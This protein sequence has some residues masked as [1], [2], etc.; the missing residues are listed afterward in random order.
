MKEE[1]KGFKH[2]LHSTR[3]SI[4]GLIHTYKSEAAFRQELLLVVVLFT[5]SFFLAS[6]FI[7]W[8]LLIFPL[9][10]LLVT[11][12]LNSAIE[13]TVDRVGEDYHKLSGI[14]K[15]TASAAVFVNLLFI[16]FTW[17]GFILYSLGVFSK[18]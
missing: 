17:L 9:F 2:L 3:N 1:S 14:A 10:T 18:L 5:A 13:S 15:D 6:N 4:K 12:L 16:G 7:E 11:E 8:C